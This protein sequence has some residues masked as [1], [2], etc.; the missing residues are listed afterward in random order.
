MESL[1]Q[2]NG[3]VL[4]R[5]AIFPFHLSQVPPLPRK[6]DDKYEVLH[7]SR[8]IILANLK[9]WCFKMQPFSGNQRPDLLTSLMN[10][11]LVVRLPRDM[12]LCRSYSNV[13]RLPSFLEILKPAR[14][15]HF[16]QGAESLAPAM[17]TDLWTAKTART[18]QFFPL[19]TWKCVSHHNGARFFDIWTPKSGRNP[20]V[21]YTFHMDMFFAPQQRAL[22][23]QLNF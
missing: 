4:M 15:A 11:S 8:K 10:M 3:R 17:R 18:R 12:H 16:W 20:S 13:P 7:L 1:V 5:F 21:F 6:S 2:S 9:I 23:W 22:F 19:L 14:F